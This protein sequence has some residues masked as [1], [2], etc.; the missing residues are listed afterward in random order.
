[1]NQHESYMN[2]QHVP[3]FHLFEASGD[4]HATPLW[5]CPATAMR[6]AAAQGAV[7]W[8]PAE[9]DEKGDERCAVVQ[10]MT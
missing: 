6:G 3:P 4:P 2:Q 8:W 5:R 10:N 1:M 9:R 7:T